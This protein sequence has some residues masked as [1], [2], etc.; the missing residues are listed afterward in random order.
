MLDTLSP[1]SRVWIFQATRKLSEFEENLI[2]KKFDDFIPE[3]AAHGNELYGAYSVEKHHF[4]VVGV[5]EAKAPPSGCSID[6]LMH[7][8][9]DLGK[10]VE[11]DFTNRLMI[12]LENTGEIKLVSMEEFKGMVRNGEVDEQSIVY[13]NLVPNKSELESS[14][15]TVVGNSWHKN[16]MTTV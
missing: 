3:W 5:D 16:L 11:I 13:N 2:R 4:I 12:A 9:E 8:I 15:R 10:E 1:T 7:L 14:W 6:K